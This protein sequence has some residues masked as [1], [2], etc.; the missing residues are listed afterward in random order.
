MAAFTTIAFS[1]ASRVRTS[2]GRRFSFTISTIREPD[3]WASTF[4][5]ASAAGMAALWGSDKPSDSTITAM[6]EAVPI[7]AQ[8]P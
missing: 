7:T 1:N 6:V 4:L 5:R 8:C 3:R 2:E